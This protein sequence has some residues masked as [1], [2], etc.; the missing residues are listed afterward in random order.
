M[1]YVP[2]SSELFGYIHDLVK[3]CKSSEPCELDFKEIYS[4]FGSDMDYSMEEMGPHQSPIY[5]H[6]QTFGMNEE[7]LEMEADSYGIMFTLCRAKKSYDPKSIGCSF[8]ANFKPIIVEPKYQVPN[9]LLREKLY[10]SILN[11]HN[12]NDLDAAKKIEEEWG[13]THVQTDEG[14]M[15]YVD[16]DDYQARVDQ[17]E[18]LSKQQQ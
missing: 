11:A 17:I 13:I 2:K 6:E 3:K 9:L 4:K 10:W 14:L 16:R 7:T 18:H 15:F 8:I 1:I 5:F 12:D